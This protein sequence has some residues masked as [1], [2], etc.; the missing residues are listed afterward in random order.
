MTDELENLGSRAGSLRP[1]HIPWRFCRNQ[2][3]SAFAG[4]SAGRIIMHRIKRAA[5]PI[6]HYKIF[7]FQ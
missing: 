4:D 2:I 1:G 5:N 3:A 7:V 6:F